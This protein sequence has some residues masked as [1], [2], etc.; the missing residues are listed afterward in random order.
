MIDPENRI[1][2]RDRFKTLDP[3]SRWS[4]AGYDYLTDETSLELVTLP[5]GRDYV[6]LEP[7]NG[8]VDGS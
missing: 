3:Q 5:T 8:L 4:A 1:A 7:N 2:R 6:P